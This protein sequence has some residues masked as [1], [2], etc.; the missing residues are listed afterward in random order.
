MLKVENFKEKKNR[1]KRIFTNTVLV[2]YCILVSCL[3]FPLSL[4][5]GIIVANLFDPSLNGFSIFRNYISNLGS[6]R[7][8]AIPPI[9]NFSVIITSL[10][11]F[12]V[13]FYFKNTIYSYQKN[14]NKTHFKKILKVLLSNLG[15]IA[16]IFA[17]IGFM[18]VGFFSENLNTHLSG[19][20][21][22][23]P[24]KWTI[25]E[26]F[27]MFFAH[28]FFISILFSGIF[29]GIY[30]LLFPK[31]VAKIFRVEKYWIIFI[32]LGIEMLGSPIINS[33]IFILS[34]N[35]SEQF[36]EW[37]I[38]FIILSWLIPLLIILLRSLTD[39]TNSIN[40][41]MEFTL[42]G[43]FFKLLANK[44]LIKYTIIIGN[45]YFLFSIFIGVIIAQFDLPGYNFMPYAKYLILLKPDPAG[46]N[47]F[48]DV[49]SN[50]GSFR[51]SPIPQI[52]NLSLMIYSI[53]LIPAALYIYKLLYSI[54]KNTELIG[55][56]AKV[57]KIFLM[58]SSI[59]LFVAIISLFG[60]GL[61]SE[62]VADYIEYL[63][64]PAFL[65]YDWHIVFA[66]IFLT[67]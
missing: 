34:I 26:S 12:P 67:S 28:T 36:Y 53:L 40:N 42:K 44:K 30:F 35:L 38:F 17:L 9:F 31:S 61:F 25:F 14:A 24:F 6:F 21:G 5:I 10:C 56:K 46:Y 45:I 13:T 27:H 29:I 65:W 3:V 8:T 16:M 49:I 59:M 62:D 60:V 22:I 47:I 23:N 57:K 19:Y 55:L 41:T 1:L 20:Y 37:I 58:L 4:I 64:G 7:H 63:Y 54:N 33:V 39:K 51:F 15:F 11:L 48:D 43:Q 50:L 32:L 66:A 52:F 18:G 2:K